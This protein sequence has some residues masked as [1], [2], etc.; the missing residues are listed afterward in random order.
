MGLA[1]VLLW[2]LVACVLIEY[3][4]AI[5]HPVFMVIGAVM[6]LMTACIAQ[7]G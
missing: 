7:I 2:I 1:L 6:V 5:D 4:R 3:G